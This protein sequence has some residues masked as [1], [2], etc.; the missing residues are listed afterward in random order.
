MTKPTS[1]SL[2][3]M[4]SSS[5]STMYF[6]EV[7]GCFWRACV[8][9][10]YDTSDRYETCIGPSDARQLCWSSR[11]SAPGGPSKTKWPSK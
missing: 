5:S 7:F 3:R 11:L 6:C 2:G 8:A 4:R 1:S 9:H 10:N